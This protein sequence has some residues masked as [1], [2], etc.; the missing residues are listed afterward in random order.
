MRPSFRDILL[1]AAWVYLL[2][3]FQISFCIPFQE[4]KI[5]EQEHIVKDKIMKEKLE[6][7]VLV[8]SKELPLPTLQV[9]PLC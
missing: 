2:E 5:K 4:P 3:D 8:L 9:S 6:G 1:D 7:M